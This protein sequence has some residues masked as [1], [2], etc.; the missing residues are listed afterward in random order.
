MSNIGIDISKAKLD[1]VVLASDDAVTSFSFDNDRHGIAKLITYLT[2]LS[3][4]CIAIEPTGGY[5]QSLFLA[6]HEASLPVAMV[7]PARVRQFARSLGQ[8]AKTDDIDARILAQFA[9]LLQPVTY[10][11]VD[12]ETREIS[13]WLVRRHQL[14]DM[15]AA[16]K[17]RLHQAK[18]VIASDIRRTIKWLEKRIAELEKSLRKKIT[19]SKKWAPKSELLRS[20]PGVGE[21]VSMT[22]LADLPELGTVN[23]KVISALVGVAPFCRDSGK[24]RGQRH[25]FGGRRRVRT[26][27]YMATIAALRCNPVIKA[28]YRKLKAQGKPSKVVLTACMHKL[29]LRLNAMMREQVPW[30]ALSTS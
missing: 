19:Q 1:G 30:S 23:G 11:L 15:V 17:A 12:A 10:P 14:V 7:E 25:I 29:L 26:M 18:D 8:R 9:Q 3:P 28:F 20:A 24:W 16:E 2:T 21:V 27:L 4:Q 5:E 13:E 6:L 22:L